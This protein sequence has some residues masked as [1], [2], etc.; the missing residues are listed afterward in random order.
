MAEKKKRVRVAHELPK[1]RRLAIKK[2]LAEHESEARPEWDRSSDWGEI[3]FLRKRIKPGEMRTVKMPLLK[4]EMGDSWPIPITVLH[5]IRP[6]PVVTIIGGTHGDELTGPSACTNL[7]SAIFTG[8]DGA[9]NPSSMAGTVRIVPVLNLPGYRTMSR[10]FP[11]GRDLNR[12]FPGHSKSN[13]T[14]RVAKRVT[15]NLIN[16]SDVIIDLHSAA[17][18]RSNMPQIRGDLSHPESNLLAKAFGIEVVLDSRPPKG[19]LRRVAN[20]MDIAAITYEGGGANWLD[21][22]AVKVAVHGC[23]NVLRSLKVIPKNPSRPRFRLNAG[24]STWL[25]A[26]EGGLL[27][28]FVSPGSVVTKGDVV[29]I[30]SDPGSPGLSV[31]IVAPEDGLMICTATNPFVTAGTPVGHILPVTKHMELLRSQIDDRGI[32]IVNGSQGEA[33]WRDD[34]DEMVEIDVSGEWSGGSIDAEWNQIYTDE[35]EQENAES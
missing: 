34:G 33:I 19:S 17:T 20:D 31:D 18:G 30:I 25:R 32:L 35:A 26:G 6:G 7:L 8:P 13:T 24:G 16:D 5:G 21:Q 27:D 9:L 2:A 15:K 1:T 14:S 28:M 3:R 10:Y 4:V 22:A 29:A 23:L 11:D 12:A